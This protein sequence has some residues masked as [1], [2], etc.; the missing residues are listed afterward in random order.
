[1]RAVCWNGKREIRVENIPD[2]EIINLR[3]AIVKVEITSIYGSDL[4]I[5]NGYIPTMKTG[6]C[7]PRGTG[8]KYLSRL[9]LKTISD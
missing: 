6:I 1:M 9:I 8:W 7:Q 2:P 3:D 4:H 5:Y